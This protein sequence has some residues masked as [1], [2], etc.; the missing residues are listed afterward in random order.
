MHTSS[1]IF[2]TRTLLMLFAAGTSF[3]GTVSPH[4]QALKPSQVVQVIIQYRSANISIS[5]A[6]GGFKLMDLPNINGE[7]SRMTAGAAATLAKESGVLNVSMDEVVQSTGTPTAVPIYD[8]MPQTLQPA[9]FLRS[10]ASFGAAN[11]E[12]GE[13]IGI[14]IIDSGIH[15]NPD[16]IGD[17][18]NNLT[19]MN[20]FPRVWYSQSFV[21]GESPDDFYGHGTHVAGMIAG[22]GSNSYGRA[23]LEDIHGIAP[24]AHLINLK[25]LDKNGQGADSQVIAAINQAILLKDV[26]NIKIINLSLGR[27]IY[28][29]Y[30]VDPLCQA[31]EKAWAAGITVVVAAGN[32]GRDNIDGTFGYGTIAA[33]ANDPRVITVGAMNTES[34]PQRR[35]DM[36][37]T[38]S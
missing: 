31:V 20:W 30:K 25:V 27:G 15:V 6:Y 35:D 14:A 21:A 16:L 7:V 4:I 33:P 19:L 22:D 3:A 28:E 8:Y 2:F 23:Y 37:T 1:Y 12:S 5:A 29:S 32:G 9:L 34:T 24:G 38:Y 26:F 10:P 36:M 17:G 18:T 11:T 13:G